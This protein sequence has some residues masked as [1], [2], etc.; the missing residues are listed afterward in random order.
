MVS[1]V[2]AAVVELITLHMIDG[3]AVL[4]NP[5]QVTQ[6]LSRPEGTVNMMLHDGVNCVV[7]LTDGSYTSVA[8]PCEE[9]RKLMEGD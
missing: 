8:E 1:I 2:L 7:R 5:K 6:L 9:V 4:I 3:R